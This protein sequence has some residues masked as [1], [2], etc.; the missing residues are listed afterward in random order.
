MSM[1]EI[2]EFTK[3]SKYRC[4]TSYKNNLNTIN[5]DTTAIGKFQMVGTTLRDLRDTKRNIYLMLNINR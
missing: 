3:G 1:D 4:V 2:F 5:K